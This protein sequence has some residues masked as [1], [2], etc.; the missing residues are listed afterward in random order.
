MGKPVLEARTAAASATITPD[1]G[2]QR[3]SVDQMSPN[4]KTFNGTR[5]VR[6]TDLD[7]LSRFEALS[8]LS[9][10]ELGLLVRTVALTNFNRSQIMFHETA[11]ASRVHILLQGIARIT[12]QSARAERITLALVPPGPIAEF[13]SLPFSYFDFRSEAYSDCRVASLSLSDFE[14]IAANRAGLVFKTFHENDLKQCYQMLLR[15]SSLLDLHERI[16]ITLLQLA[17][18]F[19]IKESRGAL[20]RVSFSH[21][22]IADLVGGSRPRVTEHL[23]RLER[24]HLIIRQGRQLIVRVDELGNAI[25]LPPS[26]GLGASAPPP[27]KESFAA[28]RKTANGPVPN[29][30]V[31]LARGDRYGA[32]KDDGGGARLSTGGARPVSM[33]ARLAREEAAAN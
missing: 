5:N 30:R 32:Q 22:D 25:G 31:E 13:P 26:S 2:R 1:R 23:A 29:P 6:D 28:S 15:T 24:E 18:D 17:S 21:Q 19:G 16:A 14:R 8:W 7:R 11:H 10:S 3:R 27:V 33:I 4:V 9:A 12:F 20:L